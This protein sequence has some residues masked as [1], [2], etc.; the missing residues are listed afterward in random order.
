MK[1]KEIYQA[2]DLSKVG[3]ELKTKL[4]ALEKA[5]DGFTNERADGNMDMAMNKIYAHLKDKKPESLKNIEVKTIEV[6]EKVETMVE[7]QPVKKTTK[8]KKKVAGKKKRLLK[9]L[10][11]RVVD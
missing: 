6:E 1:S 7:G 10:R 11:R 2:I 3:P 5:T 9:K 4:I 8:T